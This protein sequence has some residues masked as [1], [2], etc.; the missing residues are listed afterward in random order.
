MPKVAPAIGGPTMR[1]RAATDCHSPA[2]APCCSG[3]VAIDIKPESDGLFRPNPHGMRMQLKTTRAHCAR[4]LMGRKGAAAMM[5]NASARKIGPA[6]ARRVS[7]NRGTRRRI[8]HAL[9]DGGDDAHEAQVVTR[10][11]GRGHEIVE[12]RPLDRAREVEHVRKPREAEAGEH[13]LERREPEHGEEV[14]EIERARARIRGDSLDRAGTVN[15]RRPPPLGLHE[16]DPGED[17]GCQGQGRGRVAR[18]SRVLLRRELAADER[19]D[20]ESQ[21]EGCTD[22]PHGPRAMLLRR[23]VGD[24]R[25]GRRDRG[26]EEPGR[27]AAGEDER[28][29]VGSREEGVR[30]RGPKK[31]GDQYRPASDPVG[32]APP[33]R[34]EDELRQGEDCE[35]Q[36]ESELGRAVLTRVDG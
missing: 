26:A 28:Q 33:E 18:K 35:Q 24:I 12:R 1:A 17:P 31:A 9:D 4:S 25:D 3:G 23:D 10:D 36:P 2:H 21:T 11:G 7:P 32:E 34:G 16:L 14:E 8:S 5:K 19:A 29:R 22:R 30:S 15:R 6:T 20:R 13:R 27:G